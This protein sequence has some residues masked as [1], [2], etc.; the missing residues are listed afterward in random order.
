MVVDEGLASIIKKAE[1]KESELG[2]TE[3]DSKKRDFY[4]AVKLVLQGVITYANNLSIK[5]ALLADKENNSTRKKELE[6][7]SEN[8]KKVPKEKSDTFHEALQAIW[9]CHVALHQENNNTALS[10]GRLDQV[11]VCA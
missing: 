11:V 9:I 3:A 1:K 5:A 2:D 4:K 7:I 10:L 8:C 6:K